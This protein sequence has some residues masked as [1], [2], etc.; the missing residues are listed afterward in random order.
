MGLTGKSLYSVSER[1][2]T[3]RV[4][5]AFS[6]LQHRS[7]VNYGHGHGMFLSSGLVV[8]CSAQTG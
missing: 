8:L 5:R 7:L 4:W 6:T 3:E 1:A 2:P